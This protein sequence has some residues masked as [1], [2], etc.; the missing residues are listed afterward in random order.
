MRPSDRA[1]QS[2]ATSRGPARRRSLLVTG[3]IVL[4]GGLTLAACGSSTPSSSG[5][6]TTSGA[7]SS[8]A[9]QAT[10]KTASTSLGTVLVSSSGMTLYRFDQDSAGRSTCAGSCASIWPPLLLPS[11][12]R[13]PVPGGGVSGLGTITRSDGGTQVTYQNMPLYTYSGDQS[14]GQTN[15]NGV[16]GVWHVVTVSSSASGGSSSGS[17]PSSSSSG[18]NSSSSG[19][20]GYGY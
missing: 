18:S 19:S 7:T 8:T 12:H 16:G 11:G 20:G 6:T 13:T 3:A 15:G 1:E 2:A 14:A 5:S 9:S 17:T 4:A 10:V